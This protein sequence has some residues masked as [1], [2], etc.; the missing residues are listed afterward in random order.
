MEYAPDID[1]I[2]ALDVKHDAGI[3]LQDATAQTGE[4]KLIGRAPTNPMA[5]PVPAS[6]A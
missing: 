2:V 1:V 5:T 6:R 4:T 3:A